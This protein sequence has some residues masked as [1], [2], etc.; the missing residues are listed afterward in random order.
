[1]MDKAELLPLLSNTRP[2]RQH[3][4]M[5]ERPVQNNIMGTTD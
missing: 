1:M 5:L 3:S 2:I 4:P